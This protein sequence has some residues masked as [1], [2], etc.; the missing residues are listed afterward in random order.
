[1]GRRQQ[2][3]QQAQ[4]DVVLPC[5]YLAFGKDEVSQCPR[6]FDERPVSAVLYDKLT[7]HVGMLAGNGDVSGSIHVVLLAAH[8]I[9]RYLDIVEKRQQ[10]DLAAL[11]EGV[12]HSARSPRV[13]QSTRG[14]LRVEVGRP[15]DEGP[16]RQRA[17]DLRVR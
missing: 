15:R 2:L 8:D 12:C 13:R 5:Y 11:A 1:M 16:Q 10:L 7:L 6:G 17:Q 3:L 4:P 9:Y 14:D